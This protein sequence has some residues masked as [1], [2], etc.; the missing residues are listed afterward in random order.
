[1]EFAAIVAAAVAGSAMSVL[2]AI[3]GY[4]KSRISKDR[5]ITIKIDDQEYTVSKYEDVE[6]ISA[7]IVKAIKERK[8]K[9]SEVR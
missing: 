3:I 4:R 6:A 9:A 1:M 7:E 2:S 5:N 8:G